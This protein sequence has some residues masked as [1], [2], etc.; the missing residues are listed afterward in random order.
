MTSQVAQ[1]TF[2]IWSSPGTRRNAII[3]AGVNLA[4]LHRILDLTDDR[5]M[6]SAPQTLAAVAALD[7]LV[8]RTLVEDGRGRYLLR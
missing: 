8:M 5:L 4:S 6:L 3:G 2:T 1:E 7:G